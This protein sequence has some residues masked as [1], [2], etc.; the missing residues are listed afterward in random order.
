MVSLARVDIVAS[1]E[2]N[3]TMNLL[4]LK[5]PNSSLIDLS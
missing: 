2:R 1:F 3:A 5:Y 4:L